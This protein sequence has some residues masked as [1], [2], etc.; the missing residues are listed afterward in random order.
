VAD[1]VGEGGVVVERGVDYIAD[2]AARPI[3]VAAAPTIAD[4]ASR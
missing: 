4:G 3:T 1:G 2:V